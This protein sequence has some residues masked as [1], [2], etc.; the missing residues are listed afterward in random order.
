[1]TFLKFVVSIRDSYCVY[2]P[3]EPKNLATSLTVK[4]NVTILGSWWR[5]RVSL[6]LL[7]TLTSKLGAVELS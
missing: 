5:V 7:Q 3:Q 2:S 1:M 6:F 4:P